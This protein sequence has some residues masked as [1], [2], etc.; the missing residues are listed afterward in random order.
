MAKPS[1]DYDPNWEGKHTSLIEQYNALCEAAKE[2]NKRARQLIRQGQ[3]LS[4]EFNDLD[5]LKDELLGEADKCACKA[6]D[7]FLTSFPTIEGVID[8]VY[9]DDQSNAFKGG[10]SLEKP[11]ASLFETIQDMLD[12]RAEQIKLVQK[13][14]KAIQF[15][16]HVNGALE[17]S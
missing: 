17:L 4:K 15:S 14:E 8:H 10:I 5:D 1:P 16:V 12:F 7:V 2:V 6:S 3:G 11:D 13:A 9:K